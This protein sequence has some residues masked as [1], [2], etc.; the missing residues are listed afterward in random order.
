M[1][2]TTIT[3]SFKIGDKVKIKPFNTEGKVQSLWLKAEGLQIEV[4]YY[5][6]K[7][8]KY[9]YFYEDELEFITEKKTGF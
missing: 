1:S 9:E 6:E 8:R 5:T 3:S 2:G 4:R 7:E